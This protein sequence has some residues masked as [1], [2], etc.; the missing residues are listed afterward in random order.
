ME[1]GESQRSSLQIHF[2]V[3]GYAQTVLNMDRQI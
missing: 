3:D 2:A 1:R